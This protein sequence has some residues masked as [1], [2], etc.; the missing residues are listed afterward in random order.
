MEGVQTFHTMFHKRVC[1]AFKVA[2]RDALLS[3]FS[4]TT[5]AGA[6]TETVQA[7]HPVTHNGVGRAFIIVTDGWTVGRRQGKVLFEAWVLVST[8]PIVKAYIYG[9]LSACIKKLWFVDVSAFIITVDISR[10][11]ILCRFHWSFFIVV[12]KEFDIVYGCFVCRNT[13]AFDRPTSWCRGIVRQ[14]TVIQRKLL[15]VLKVNQWTS[16]IRATHTIGRCQSTN[17]EISKWINW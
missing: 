1:R 9:L 4:E 5:Q 11:A 6:I 10:E 3:L 13:R 12:V 15:L 16:R 2:C 14:R 7:F 17:L 8:S